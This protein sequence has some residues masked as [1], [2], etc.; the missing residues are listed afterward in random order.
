MQSIL[1][2]ANVRGRNGRSF[3]DRR[4]IRH[5]DVGETL[6]ACRRAIRVTTNRL[7]GLLLAPYTLKPSLLQKISGVDPKQ[8]FILHDRRLSIVI[9]LETSSLENRFI[10]LRFRP[11]LTRNG[12]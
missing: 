9:E 10:L 11:S 4:S 6:P 5:M 1:R 3:V 12:P 7:V 8:K 2:A